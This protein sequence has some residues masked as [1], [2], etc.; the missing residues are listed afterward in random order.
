MKWKEWKKS[1]EKTLIKAG[2]DL[3]TVEINYI[4]SYAREELLIST[5]NNDKGIGLY[6]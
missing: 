2:Y 3:K 5:N 4:D 1:V 6:G